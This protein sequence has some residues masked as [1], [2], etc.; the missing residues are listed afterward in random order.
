MI[1]VLKSFSAYYDKRPVYCEC[2]GPETL[3]EVEEFYVNELIE[4]YRVQLDGL[5]ENVDFEI[6]ED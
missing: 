4:D 6:I 5:T 3:W 1:K 2:C